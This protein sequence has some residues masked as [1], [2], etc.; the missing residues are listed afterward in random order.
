MKHL[1]PFFALTLLA[2]SLT[3]CDSTVSPDTA[4]PEL[5]VEDD[6]AFSKRPTPL[7][8]VG[9]SPWAG[10]VQYRIDNKGRLEFRVTTTGLPG[11]SFRLKIE[12]AGS[13]LCTS[14]SLDGKGKDV[15]TSNLP[16]GTTLL[17]S[18]SQDGGDCSGTL[19][20]SSAP[21]ALP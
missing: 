9:D 20:A 8:P 19:L 17:V 18:I 10:K 1:T 14:R 6:F 5:A 21:I 13:S 12:S 2:L 3:A 7:V 16:A 15:Y 4:E 11:E